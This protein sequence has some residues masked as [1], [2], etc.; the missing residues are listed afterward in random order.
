[1]DARYTERPTSIGARAAQLSTLLMFAILSN[2]ES[3][4][5]NCGPGTGKSICACG[6]TIAGTPYSFSA[7]LDCSGAGDK[8]TDALRVASGV[9][10]NCNSFG[11]LGGSVSNVNGFVIDKRSNVVLNDCTARNFWI[12]MRVTDSTGVVLENSTSANNLK[13]NLDITDVDNSLSPPGD[14]LTGCERVRWYL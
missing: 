1:M 2:S 14:H 5:A 3:L 11:V 12:G 13:Y 10:V 6:D 7:D 9:T 8:N 4:A